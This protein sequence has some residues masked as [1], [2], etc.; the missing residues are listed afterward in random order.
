ML[1]AELGVE[2]G[3][4]TQEIAPRLRN[5]KASGN[6][7]QPKVVR[8]NLAQQL[9]SLVGRTTEIEHIYRLVQREPLVT[10]LGLGGVGKS[11]LAQAVAQKAL[12]DFADGIWFVSLANI[13]ATDNAPDRIALAI[14]AAIDFA[15]T[16][17]QAPLP[18]LAAH[19]IDKELLLVLD[20]W[21]QITT[22]AETLCEQLLALAGVHIL[23]TSRVRLQVEGEILVQ[24]EGLPLSEAFTLFVER[25]RRLVPTFAGT[26]HAA[27]YKICEE[28]GGL[29]LGI[30]LA[31]SWVEHIG[32]AEI[33]QSLAEI[34]VEPAQAN[35]LIH[36]HQTLYTVFE[37]SWRLLSPHQQQILAQA[38]C[39][40][41]AVLTGWRRSP[42]P[43]AT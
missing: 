37:Y 1:Q 18:E 7:A 2:P 13:E 42:W 15:V 29:P 35:S 23:A 36:R 19:L 21:D 14:A 40:F 31:A 30:E 3:L 33:G 38:L 27:I 25:A 32:V 11:R 24:L 39:P 41:E 5:H 20:N 4:A 17:M 12:H 22:A 43:V 6:A 9:K 26:E 28:V 10:L 34:A 16:D 8:N